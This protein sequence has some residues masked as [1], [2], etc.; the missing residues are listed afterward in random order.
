MSDQ[1]ARAVAVGFFEDVS[2]GRTGEAWARLAPDVIYDIV[3]PAPFGGVVDRDGLGGI[4]AMVSAALATKLT[5]EIKGVISEGERA[6]IEVESHAISTHGKKYNNRYH[7]LFVV[8]SGLIVEAR[9][10]LDSAHLL[11]VCGQS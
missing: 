2:A 9:E 11:D 6:A 5:L 3:A 7:F 4:Y 10:Y 1:T 8:R